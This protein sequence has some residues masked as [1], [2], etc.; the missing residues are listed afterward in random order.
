[1]RIRGYIWVTLT[2]DIT[3]VVRID[4]IIRVVRSD[5]IIRII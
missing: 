3:R 5:R 2:K 1:M 4:R